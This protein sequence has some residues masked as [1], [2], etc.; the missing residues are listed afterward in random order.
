V[1]Y[2][3]VRKGIKTTDVNGDDIL[4]KHEGIRILV[5]QKKNKEILQELKVE[6][7]DEKL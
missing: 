7:F 6:T 5:D 3:Y 2:T 4:Q 1:F